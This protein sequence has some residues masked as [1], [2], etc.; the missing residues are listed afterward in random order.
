MG[1]PPVM[2]SLLVVQ[3]TLQLKPEVRQF[4]GGLFNLEV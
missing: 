4:S 2:V 3:A 1:A